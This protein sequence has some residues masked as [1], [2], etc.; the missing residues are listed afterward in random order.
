MK[1]LYF[2]GLLLFLAACSQIPLE[3]QEANDPYDRDY[4]ILMDALENNVSSSCK[5]ISNEHW[6][7]WCY[8]DVAAHTQD[9]K[10]CDNLQ[11]EEQEHCIKN[12]GIAL[13][14]EDLCTSIEGSQAGDEC[15]GVIALEL[16]DAT[17]CSPIVGV[18]MKNRCF[19]DLAKEIEDYTLCKYVEQDTQR[20]DSCLFRVTLR[21]NLTEGCADIFVPA[22][23]NIC[24]VNHAIKQLDKTICEEI[25]DEA[26]GRSCGAA[27]NLAKQKAKAEAAADE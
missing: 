7:N 9:H 11:E 2:A 12:V 25:G 22:T 16:K 8:T 1:Q 10:V 15:F 6:Q 18:D 17:L 3:C 23:R 21:T 24:Y 19:V 14:D 27:V 20:R 26:M 4:C 13:S 5:L